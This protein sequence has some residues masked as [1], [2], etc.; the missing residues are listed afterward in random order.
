MGIL[1]ANKIPV[2]GRENYLALDTSNRE[3][4][5][6]ICNLLASMGFIGGDEPLKNPALIAKWSK[7]YNFMQRRCTNTYDANR[8]DILFRYSDPSQDYTALYDVGALIQSIRNIL[9]S[10]YK[11]SAFAYSSLYTYDISF[12]IENELG[13]CMLTPTEQENIQEKLLTL[14]GWKQSLSAT[15]NLYHTNHMKLLLQLDIGTI[16]LDMSEYVRR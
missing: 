7:H 5:I 14:D 10:Q 8:P 3:R 16:I 6:K 15:D 2:Y 11:V 4:E 9:P 1:K 12:E 13:L